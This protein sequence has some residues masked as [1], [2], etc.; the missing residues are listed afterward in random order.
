MICGGREFEQ[1]KPT[2]T[3]AHTTRTHELKVS[4][5]HIHRHCS[6]HTT[7]TTTT[8]T[9]QTNTLGAFYMHL[10]MVI[11]ELWFMGGE[12]SNRKLTTT[13]AH[14]THAHTQHPPALLWAHNNHNNNHNTS[15]QHIRSFLYA[16]KNGKWVVEDD[17]GGISFDS[18]RCT[19]AVLAWMAKKLFLRYGFL[20]Q[21]SNA[22]WFSLLMRG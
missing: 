15:D 5:T 12:K 8:T 22:G 17:W 6:E 10:R 21:F 3:H 19:G 4:H 16:F 13:H 9:H 7:T 11:L 14:N 2:T 20:D 1:E 18:R